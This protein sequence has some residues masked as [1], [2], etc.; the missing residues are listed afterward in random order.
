M[1]INGQNGLAEKAGPF[2]ERIE[3]LHA[4][5]ESKRGEYMSF[6][7]NKRADIKSVLGEAKDAGIPVKAMKGLI[8]YRQLERKQKSIDDDFDIDESA[9]Y[10]HLVEQMGE[11]GAAAA[12]R[13][14]YD[15]AEQAAQ[16]HA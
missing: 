9:A 8:E 1:T 3:N 4:D 7:K 2:V 13:A 14:G 11:L 5:M 15:E 6:C 12:R 10:V 16:H